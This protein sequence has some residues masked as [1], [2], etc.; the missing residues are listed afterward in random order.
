MASNDRHKLIPQIGVSGEVDANPQGL[1]TGGRITQVTLSA[2]AWTA[3][4][5]VPLADRNQINVQNE[6]GTDIYIGHDN[7]EPGLIGMLVP[8][9]GERQYRI[10][11]TVIIYAKAAAGAPVVE[12]EELA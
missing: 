10:K 9:G 12:V 3:L 2:A 8:D 7:T 5:A 4:P 1:S 11:D 6:S